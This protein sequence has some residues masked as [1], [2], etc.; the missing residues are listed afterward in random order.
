MRNCVRVCAVN[1]MPVGFSMSADMTNLT[2]ISVCKQCPDG[3]TDL[4]VVRCVVS[5]Q[6]GSIYGEGYL[7]VLRLYCLQ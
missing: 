1:N 4:M 2:V 5:N 6:F 3:N 7:N